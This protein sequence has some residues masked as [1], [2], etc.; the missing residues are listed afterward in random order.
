MRQQT[1]V[2]LYRSSSRRPSAATHTIDDR[3]ANDDDAD[4]LG[5][6]RARV[7]RPP[8][9]RFSLSPREDR[10]IRLDDV[11]G[12]SAVLFAAAV[13]RLNE[14]EEKKKN[15]CRRACVC[16]CIAISTSDE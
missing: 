5:R 15:S 13:F 4:E 8:A 14:R 16:V 11:S 6:R 1:R 3:R 7:D 12:E 9:E 2:A 10:L